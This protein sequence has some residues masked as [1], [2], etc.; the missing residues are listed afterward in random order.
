VK[1]TGLGLVQSFGDFAVTFDPL[2]VSFIDPVLGEAAEWHFRQTII[3][4]E[5]HVLALA[6]RGA[7]LPVDI[8][9]VAIEVLLAQSASGSL[10]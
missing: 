5:R 10:T 2:Q 7:V 6:W 1:A 4:S 9:P 3:G 8:T